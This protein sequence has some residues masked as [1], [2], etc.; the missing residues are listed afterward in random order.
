MGEGHAVA[1]QRRLQGAEV[2]LGLPGRLL[3]ASR[4]AGPVV[5][6]AGQHQPDP[7]LLGR[8][9]HGE[10]VFVA[11]VVDVEEVDGGGDA[12]PGHLGE[13]EHGPGLDG[14]S[15]QAF[16]EGIEHQVPPPGE[17]QVVAEPSEQGLEGVAVAV[18]RPG[19]DGDLSPV[20][21]F[22]ARVQLG[23]L[24]RLTGVQDAPALHHERVFR[25]PAILGE[26][27]VGGDERH[28]AG[29]ADGQGFGGCPAAG[30][31][32]WRTRRH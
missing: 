10:V 16:G 27:Q 25:V 6:R 17:R 30:A 7:D 31:V 13:V 5:H 23:E 3:E 1:L 20:L 18:D 32:A 2:R 26:H 4:R 11:P 19:Q 9:D 8:L 22:L 24:R 29:I 12:R 28:A 15:V 14:L 21:A